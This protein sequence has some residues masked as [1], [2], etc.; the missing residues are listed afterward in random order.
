MVAFPAQAILRAWIVDNTLDAGFAIGLVVA[1]VCGVAMLLNSRGLTS[2]FVVGAAMLLACA[3]L[4]FL[5]LQLEKR[6]LK[7]L[8][9]EDLTRLRNAIAFDPEN[10][11]AHALLGEKLLESR[12]YDAARTQI[13]TAMRLLPEGAQTNR[14]KAL[15]REVD[16]QECEAQKRRATLAKLW[17][18]SLR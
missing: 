17:R 4:P 7:Q 1:Q 10:A 9:T 18:P 11:S 16:R 2:A 6:S 14:W 15:L 13:E 12:N 5:W 8:E 3:V